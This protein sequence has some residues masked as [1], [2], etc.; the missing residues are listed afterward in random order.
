MALSVTTPVNSVSLVAV[1][2]LLA[3]VLVLVWPGSGV[4]NAQGLV[5]H[6]VK[7]IFATSQMPHAWMGVS[8]VGGVANVKT[9]ATDVHF[10]TVHPVLVHVRMVNGELH[11]K[12]IVIVDVRYL[13]LTA[14]LYVTGPQGIAHTLVK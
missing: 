14:S 10:V 9:F 13:Q 2:Y 12:R 8:V 7:I 5:A 1:M 4:P 3:S 11:A 6:F